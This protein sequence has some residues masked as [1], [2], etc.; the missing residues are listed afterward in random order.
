VDA[1]AAPES[2][3]QVETLKS[4]DGEDPE[5]TAADLARQVRAW[6]STPGSS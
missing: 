3:V 4:E 6:S 5:A 1:I 2:G